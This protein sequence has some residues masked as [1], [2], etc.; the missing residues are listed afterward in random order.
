M[1]HFLTKILLI[2]MLLFTVPGHATNYL[3]KTVAEITTALAKVQPGDTLL[4]A[5]G[6][7]NNA[8]IVFRG[9]G[10][11]TS[12][13]V[14]RAEKP[15]AVILTG[16]STLRFSGSY[17]IADGL[18]FVGGYSPSGAVVEFRSGAAANYC[19]LTNSAIV[20]YNPSSK[21]TDYKW[22][23]LYGAYNRVD[24][25]YFAGKNHMGTTLVVW[26]PYHPHYHRIDH[27]YFAYRPP[28]GENGGETIRIG[29][30]DYSM[31][32]S[33]TIVEYN[34][35][36]QCNGEIEI[37]SNKSCENIYRY[38]TFVDCEG[39]LTLR[40]GN[41]CT[42]AGNFFFGHRNSETGGVRI[43]G[44]EHL[45]YNNYFEGLYG[46]SLKSA[47]PIMNGVPNSPL[48]RYFQVK[49][50]VVAFNT[51]VDCRYPLILGAGHDSERSL[52][53]QDC[54]IANN[55][56]QG[57]YK[58]ITQEDAPVNLTWEGNIYWGSSLG[59]SQPAGIAFINP[60]L[61]LV[62]DGLWRP[63]STSPVYSSAAGSYD[64]ITDD[65]DGQARGMTKDVGA[66]QISA[67]PV[68]R[69]PLTAQDVMPEWMKHPI[70]L[71]VTVL[72]TGAG[73]V[74][75]DPPGGV[76]D[77]GTPVTL[78]AIPNAGWKFM[79]WEG[80]SY[81]TANP[82]QISVQTDTTL[83]AVFAAD[84]PTLYK[85]TVFVFSSGGRVEMDPPGG[86]YPP[87][88]MVHLTAIPDSGWR[89][90]QFDGDL[91]STANPESLVLDGEKMVLAVFSQTSQVQGK[92][93]LLQQYQLQQN[94]P[95]PFNGSTQIR[96]SIQKPG[97]TIL[98]IFT[99]HGREVTTL[100]D[101]VLQPGDY[102]STFT[103]AQMAS[104]VYLYQFSCEEYT[105]TKKM[106]LIN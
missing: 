84:T 44:E 76:Y 39:A 62:A 99:A 96:F 8:A 45:V 88:T 41:R 52:P 59:I 48:N 105:E 103:N 20:N 33:R 3:V 94:Y 100:L 68:L 74:V 47:L 72:K 67:A 36:E 37:I 16:T 57:N 14:L 61:Q 63:D 60:V 92:V 40:H 29:T 18:R 27:N 80:V 53:P 46:S 13:I 10:T 49:K 54:I 6:I 58:V 73:N 85:L 55:V 91:V 104:G 82:L 65:M 4:M 25:C 97:R 71:V 23:S 1:N 7:W 90:V 78:T 79:H 19:R 95:N 12:P 75:L 11:E 89:F 43:I 5:A 69:R 56:V 30:S 9:V 34:Y 21:S 17:L 28:L 87:N 38:N 31:E 66:D 98:R 2:L 70:P 93:P 24:H 15:G 35:F 77:K 81:D 86:S 42:V 32:N 106:I 83:R 102:V 51:L 26:F 50:A 64:Y 22:V 101:R